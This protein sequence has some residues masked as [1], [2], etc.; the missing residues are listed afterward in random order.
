MAIK[1][2]FKHWAR[3]YAIFAIIEIIFAAMLLSSFAH[4]KSDD[5]AEVVG[6]SIFSIFSTV[7]AAGALIPTLCFGIGAM[8]S[9]SRSNAKFVNIIVSFALILCS[10]LGIFIGSVMIG[11]AGALVFCGLLIASCLY[12][13]I[14]GF[15]TASKAE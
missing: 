7:L 6:N 12:A 11:W 3:M 5:V 14:S 9:G 4:M 2:G 8:I 15:V 1:G 10:F 13:T